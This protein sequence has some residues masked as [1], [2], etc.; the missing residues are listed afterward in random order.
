MHPQ[1][2]PIHA[3]SRRRLQSEGRS[4]GV[5]SICPDLRESAKS[6]DAFLFI[7]PVLAIPRGRRVAGASALAYNGG[8][9]GVRT[10]LASGSIL[11]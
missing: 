3:D 8:S 11:I 1:I 4:M 7:V 6:A 5:Y 2:S 10:F 9:G